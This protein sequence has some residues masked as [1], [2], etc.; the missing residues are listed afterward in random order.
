[1]DLQSIIKQSISKAFKE[2]YE[3]DLQEDAINLQPTRKEFEGTFTLVTFPFTGRLKLNP[4]LVG[5]TIGDFLTQNTAEIKGY[6]VLKG[7]LNLVIEDSVWI[8]VFNDILSNPSFG[9]H[10]ANN[11]TVMVEYSSPNTNKPL[12]LGHLRNNF[13]GYSLAEILKT[14]G[15]KVVKANLIN[16]RGI[17]ICKSML[18]YQNWGNNETPESENI[19]GD[20][21]I[22][23]Y[24][25]KFDQEY[26]KEIEQL[27]ADGMDKEQAKLKAP[28]FLQAQELL[29]QWEAGDEETVALWEKLNNWVYDG[30]NH[31]YNLI[32]VDFDQFYYESNTYLLGKDIVNDGLEKGVFYKKED[33]SI[34]ADLS[35]T[36]LDDKLVL[37]GDGTS[38][39]ITQDMGTADLKY[40]DY[41]VDKSIYVVGNEQDHHFKVLQ[42]IL[43]NLG[44]S[45]AEGIYH[46]SYGMVDLPSGKMKS[47]EG[48]VVDADDL[49]YEMIATAKERTDELGK[50]DGFT[51]EQ[52]QELYRTLAL[53][54]LKYFILK[55]DPK[56]KMLFNPEESI[57]EKGNTGPFIQYNYARICSLLRKGT[58]MGI[59]S[60]EAISIE[61]MEGVERDLIVLM[62][63]FPIV[64]KEAADI[65]S[66]SIIAQYVYELAKTYSRFFN[67][68]PIFKN[69][70][71]NIIKY[72]LTLSNAAG[73]IIEK[74]MNLLGINVPTKM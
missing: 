12:H 68:C 6:N 55:V 21:L 40:D 54:A 47:R 58:E 29:R 51:E 42:T 14:A 45:Y 44:R 15:Y 3:L 38:V 32:G 49:V 7:F 30:F 61:N 13:L 64:V 24:Y 62:N 70:D 8:N 1:M 17:H 74:G 71:T 9:Q 36:K 69:E 11:Q 52:A 56:R 4:E 22:G 2:V 41:K 35:K 66:P 72:R 16:D 65:Y 46:M 33:N 20:H 23:K 63:N 34:W 37:R 60:N 43:A 67:E 19:K 53:G 10:E 28:L 18:A 48:T 39:Y 50:I 5:N 26:K 73:Q 59:N 31:T 25:V 27:V 57:D